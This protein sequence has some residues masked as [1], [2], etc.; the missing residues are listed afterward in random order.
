MEEIIFT[1]IY[2][3]GILS[4]V[5]VP[6]YVGGC[7]P[8]LKYIIKDYFSILELLYYT[9]E[10]EYETVGG[11]YMN[12]LLDTAGPRC[13]LTND[14]IDVGKVVDL[15][16]EGEVVNLGGESIDV[17]LGEEGEVVNLGGEDEDVN[18]GG[19]EGKVVNLGGE[20]ADVN[21]GG[22]GEHVNLGGKGVDDDNLHGEGVDDNLGGEG[23]FDF[24]SSDSDLGD[25]PSENGSDID[26][27]LR[28]FRQER[29]NKKQRKKATEYKE[30]PVGEAGCIDR[31]FEDIGKNKIDK[32]AGKLG[33][34]E[35]YL[36]SSDF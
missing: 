36:N 24:L 30:I 14:S 33:G 12:P 11:F 35:D 16:G 28:A 8:A 31:G 19:E 2:H 27:E 4:E 5:S 10:L 13:Y 21:L 25:M 22:E 26:E 23:E 34:D 17:N 7:V 6:T 9:K 20:D 18:L 32:Y 1:K 29:R 3:G 15:S